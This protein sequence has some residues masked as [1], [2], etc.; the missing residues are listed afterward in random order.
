MTELLCRLNGHDPEFIG[1]AI[2]MHQRSRLVKCKRCEAIFWG[3]HKFPLDYYR[4]F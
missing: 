4:R 1:R 2:V 3:H